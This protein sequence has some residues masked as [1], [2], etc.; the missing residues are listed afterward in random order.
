MTRDE[1]LGVLQEFLEDRIVDAPDETCG[2]LARN[3]W[4]MIAEIDE[5]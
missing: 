5:S 3:L 2:T 4:D 1:W